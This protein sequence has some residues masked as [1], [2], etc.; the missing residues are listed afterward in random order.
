MHKIDPQTLNA[1]FPFTSTGEKIRIEVF[2]CSYSRWKDS[3][4]NLV[5]LC[6]RVDVGCVWHLVWLLLASA[7]KQI[8]AITT[9]SCRFFNIIHWWCFWIT[10]LYQRTEWTFSAAI[11]IFAHITLAESVHYT[12]NIWTYILKPTFNVHGCIQNSFDDK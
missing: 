9:D 10:L 7:V 1:K 12:Q 8:V 3:I 4:T 5:C 11:W 2:F 6:S